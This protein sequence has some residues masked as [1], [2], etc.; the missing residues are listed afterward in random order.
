MKGLT[1]QERYDALKTEYHLIR[2]A[3]RAGMS[4]EQNIAHPGSVDKIRFLIAERDT[5][6]HQYAELVDAIKGK[7]I[8]YKE[9]IAGAV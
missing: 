2:A 1:I 9:L 6:K 5:L 3:L 7:R 4:D 8:T